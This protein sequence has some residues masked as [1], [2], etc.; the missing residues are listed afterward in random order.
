[1]V[2]DGEALQPLSR[3]QESAHDTFYNHIEKKEG[4]LPPRQQIPSPTHPPL[5]LL[6]QG[7]APVSQ[8]VGLIT[9]VA[10]SVDTFIQPTYILWYIPHVTLHGGS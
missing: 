7:G 1:M 4:S 10:T 9:C 3:K 2:R 6:G 5:W 8:G